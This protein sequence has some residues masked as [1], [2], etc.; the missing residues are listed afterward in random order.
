MVRFMGS[1]VVKFGHAK[2]YKAACKVW[3]DDAVRLGLP[4]Y[5]YFVSNWGRANEFFY[6]AEFEDSGDF[7]RRF[8]VAEAANDPAYDAATLELLSHVVDGHVYSWM[9][10]D[11]DLG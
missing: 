1:D 7:E 5:R 4:A 2:A 6:E 9:L 10:S 11:V 8:A 3:N